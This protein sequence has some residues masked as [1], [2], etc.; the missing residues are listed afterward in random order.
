MP[1]NPNITPSPVREEAVTVPAPKAFKPTNLAV[2]YD[3]ERT[4]FKDLPTGRCFSTKD[5]LFEIEESGKPL[6]R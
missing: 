2:C 6:K 5:C 1:S 3:G 4:Y